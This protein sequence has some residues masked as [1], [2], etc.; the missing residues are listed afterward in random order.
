MSDDWDDYFPFEGSERARAAVE[1][2]I[3]TPGFREHAR[4]VRE[5]SRAR[6]LAQRIEAS[7]RDD[8]GRSG[9]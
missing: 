4:R 3:K 9:A 6:I 7:G 8:D 1:R 5:A 2:L